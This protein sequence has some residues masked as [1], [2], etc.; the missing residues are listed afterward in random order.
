MLFCV[1]SHCSTADVWQVGLALPVAITYDDVTMTES[2]LN[3]QNPKRVLVTGGGRRVG[4][5]IVL[6]LA[7]DGARIAVHFHEHE[8]EAN[9]TVADALA[10]GASDAW[11][12]Q[13]DVSCRQD[14]LRLRD[15]MMERWGGLDA[16][17]HNA[18][19]FSRTP[20][21]EAT[22]DDWD[23]FQDINCKS[24]FLG[25]QVLAPVLTCSLGSIV[26]IADVA[27][28]LGWPGYIPYSVSKAGV[29]ALV[30]GLAKLLAPEIR[31][32]AVSPG[33]VLL[34]DGLTEAEAQRIAETIPM[35]R[36]GSPGDVADAVAYLLNATYVT[37]Q[38]LRVDG[39]RS[40]N[41]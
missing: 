40:L 29:L 33:P 38:N 26:A 10:A 11:A 9:R 41:G 15:A 21:F 8:S 35:E 6:R 13:A 22:E 28:E 20:F 4:R 12:I 5:A 17:V 1:C 18:A 25:A 31:V 23:R 3:N 34:A 36:V 7:A 14:W 37:G 19:V 30:R 2:N 16:L 27:G 32:N 39:G 24:L